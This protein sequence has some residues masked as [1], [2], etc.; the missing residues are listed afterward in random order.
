LGAAA[1][2]R[3]WSK[4]ADFYQDDTV[5]LPPNAPA[6]IGKVK[7]IEAW[8]SSSAAYKDWRAEPLE[9]GGQGDLAFVRGEW[10]IIMT[11]AN[12]PEHSDFGKYLHIWRRQSDSSWKLFR[13]IWNSDLP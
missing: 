10:S 9:I 8:R 7:V 3:N 11:P 4:V 12:Q 2:A 6:N 1:I 13:D 5:G